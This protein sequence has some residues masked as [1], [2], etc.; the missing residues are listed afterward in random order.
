MHSLIARIDAV[1]VPWLRRWSSHVLRIA[2]GSVF[3]WFGALKVLGVSPVFD[4]VASTVYWVDPD[5]FVPMLGVVEIL[6]GVGLIGGWLLRWVLL[7]F[8]VQMIG[9]ALV[10][11]VHPEV[12]FQDGNPLKLTVEGEFVIKNLVL[13][14]AGLIVGSTITPKH[15][16]DRDVDPSRAAAAAHGSGPP[17]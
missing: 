16:I 4:L 10:F 6:I 7:A 14:A 2:L 12:A 3:V 8:V 17:V 13:L 1:V 9:T 11:V 5:W 15:A